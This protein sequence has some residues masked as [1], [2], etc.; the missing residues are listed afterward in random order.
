MRIIVWRLVVQK[1]RTSAAAQNF[2]QILEKMDLLDRQF[3]SYTVG[4]LDRGE[5][6]CPSIDFCPARLFRG[7]DCGAVTSHYS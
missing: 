4:E 6:D 2:G 7:G 1:E 3:L 5:L